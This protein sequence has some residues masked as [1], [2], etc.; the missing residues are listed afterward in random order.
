MITRNDKLELLHLKLS[1]PHHFVN[2]LRANRNLL[3]E[4]FPVLFL[5]DKIWA[6]FIGMAVAEIS[7]QVPYILRSWNESALD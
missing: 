6:M 7:S 1:V 5:D 3:C 2:N 4:A